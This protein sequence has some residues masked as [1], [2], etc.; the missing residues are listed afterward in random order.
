MSQDLV[1]HKIRRLAAADDVKSLIIA[2][3]ITGPEDLQKVKT[4]MM[5]RIEH[6]LTTS[7]ETRKVFDSL[8]AA[9]K[10]AI[11]M[12]NEL[13]EPEEPDDEVMDGEFDKMFPVEH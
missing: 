4:L 9:N 11:E 2:G 8:I 7:D 13:P 12:L 10:A 5:E 3:Q 1:E 6:P